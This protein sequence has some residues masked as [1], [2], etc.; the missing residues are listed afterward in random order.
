MYGKKEFVLLCITDNV[1]LIMSEL[2]E[3]GIDSVAYGEMDIKARSESS[4][5]WK[6]GE[7]K[8]MVATSAFGMH[9]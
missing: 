1:S 7:V 8:V 2:S 5:K 9:C 4:E 6:N 3:N